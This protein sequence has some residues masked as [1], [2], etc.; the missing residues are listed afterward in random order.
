MTYEGV[1]KSFRTDLITKYT[2]SF[3]ITLCCPL[4]RVM[5]AKLTRLSHKIA[6]KLRLMAESYTICSSRS[7]RPVRKL[8]GTPSKGL[9]KY[10]FLLLKDPFAVQSPGFDSSQS[11]AM[12]I[13]ISVIQNECKAGQHSFCTYRIRQPPSLWTL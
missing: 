10:R 9:R 3:V 13:F 5:V 11:S 2:L 8:L 4:Q 12:D 1:S 6:M 7:R